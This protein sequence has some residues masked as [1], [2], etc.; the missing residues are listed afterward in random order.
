MKVK[1]RGE[2]VKERKRANRKTVLKKSTASRSE[3]R[4]ES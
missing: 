4:L 3:V 2:K 1:E